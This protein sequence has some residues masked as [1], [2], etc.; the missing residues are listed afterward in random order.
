MELSEVEKIQSGY[1]FHTTGA[2][3][4]QDLSNEIALGITWRNGAL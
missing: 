3:K 2:R 4:S 1:F